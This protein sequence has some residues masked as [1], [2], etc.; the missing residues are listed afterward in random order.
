M[1]D[2]FRLRV[3]EAADAGVIAEH[4]ARM[5]FDMGAVSED[6]AGVLEVAARPWIRGLIE[7]GKYRGWVVER[8]GAVVAGGGL[9]LRELGPVP[10]CLRVGRAAHI[11]NVYTAPEWR[12][13]GLA[14]RI[15]E[16]ML[17]W[18]EQAGIDQVTLTASEEGRGLYE[19]LGF[20]SGAEM[21][22]E[23]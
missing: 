1:M 17:R 5:F 21:R 9:H 13:R 4:R 20:V 8:E 14:R 18:C 2:E 16:T 23:R 12:R 7:A 22:L 19:A 3:V 11:A 15:V 10:G 6:E